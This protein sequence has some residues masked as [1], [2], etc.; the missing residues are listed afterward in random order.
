MTKIYIA[1][2]GNINGPNK[3]LENTPNYI[4][5]ALDKGYDVE[6]DLRY[7]DNQWL[8]GHDQADTN[9][10]ESF[11]LENKDKLW[12]HA[13]NL[14]ALE[15]LLDIKMACLWHQDDYYTLTSNGY[16]WTYPGHS[17]GSRSIWVM[18]ENTF[19]KYNQEYFLN[20]VGICS[21]YIGDYQ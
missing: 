16:I 3:K 18:P 4:L 5:A 13:K 21:D 11:L 19:D 6:I 20:C 14:A 2:R 9:I 17:I 8:L 7:L 12:C 15:K 10:A 1:H